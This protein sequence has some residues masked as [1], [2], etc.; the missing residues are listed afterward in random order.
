MTAP[1]FAL[2]LAG[3]GARGFAHAG[4]LRALEDM[5]LRPSALVGVSMGSVIAVT[6]ALRDDW[7]EAL[8]ALDTTGAPSP[9]AGHGSRASVGGPGVRRAWAGARAAWSLL[10]GWGAPDEAVAAGRRS[11][12][13]VVS[14]QRLE[15]CR[16]PVTVC[17]TDLLSGSRVEM[18][19]GPAA[20]AVLA[21]SSLAGVL[22]PVEIDG[23]LLVDGVYA[24][25]APVDVAHDMGAPVVIAVD[26]TQPK[27]PTPPR[28]GLQVVMRAM[29]ICHMNHTHERIGTADLVIRPEFDGFVD[30]LDFGKREMCV[31]AG[32]RAT[33]EAEQRIRGL[34]VR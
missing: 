13:S 24:D 21:S 18:N 23:R 32:R 14:H 10:S 16:I 27:T 15:D 20:T 33:V 5:G 7:Y 6:Y 8:L 11:L 22:P 2:V 17:A 3:G 19:S 4:V 9:G 1:P 31:E 28:N 29:E 25:I 30:V 26:P 34:L 12:E